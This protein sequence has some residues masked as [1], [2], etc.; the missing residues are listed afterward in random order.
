MSYQ[1]S[2]HGRNLIFRY[3]NWKFS[4]KVLSVLF[5][6]IALSIG[7]LSLYNYFTLSSNTKEVKGDELWNYSQLSLQRAGDVITGSVKSLQALALSPS[8]I[9]L[10]EEANQTYSSMNQSQ[11]QAMIADRDE[12]WKSSIQMRRHWS[13]RLPEIR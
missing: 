2:Q 8:L 3:S 1:P 11:I 4:T 10:A 5:L 9:E 12:A 6:V 13:V 7:S